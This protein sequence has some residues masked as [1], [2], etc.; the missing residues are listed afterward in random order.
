MPVGFDFGQS[1]QRPTNRLIFGSTFTSGSLRTLCW[2]VALIH[3]A[4]QTR[5]ELTP[6]RP[7]YPRPQLQ[8]ERWLNLNGVW[9][10]EFDD[11]DVGRRR[12]WQRTTAAELESTGGPLAGTIVVPFCPESALSGVGDASFHRVA[13]YG[14]T[15]RTPEHSADER[16]LLNFGAID[17]WAEVWIN[18]EFAGCHEGGHAPFSVD[19]SGY[20]TQTVDTVVVRAEDPGDDPTIPRGKQDWKEQPS[21]IFYNRST[22][23]WQTVW[24]EIVD[25]LHVELL[26]L[27]PD[28]DAG[29]IEVDIR[30]KGWQPG[31]HVRVSC[32]L[33]GEQA[34]AASQLAAGPDLRTAIVL[35]K[36]RIESW[37]PSSPTL[38]DLTIEVV[39]DGGHVRDLV[40]SY[41][42]MRKIEVVGDELRLNGKSVFLRLVLDQGYW[43]DG[44]FTAPSDDALRQDI[45]LA[46]GM[47]F[48]GARKHQKPEDPRWLYWAD[49]LGFLVWGEMANAYSFSHDSVMRTIREW[50]GI[51][52][53]DYNHPCLIAWVPINESSGCRPLADDQRSWAGTFAA[54]YPTTIYHLTKTL[55]PTRP[56]LSNCGAEHT[57]SDF[58]TIHDYRDAAALARRVSSLEDLLASPPGVPPVFADGYAY[59]GQ[60]IFVS[61]YGGIF[62]ARLDDFSYAFASDPEDLA[63]KLEELTSVLLAS[64]IVAGFAYTQLADTAH[65]QNGLLTADR[66]PKIPLERVNA[67]VTSRSIRESD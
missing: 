42:G 23:I 41:F 24:M 2:G 34:G 37:S 21:S 31:T 63:K 53:R 15:V 7:E 22:G 8:R 65:E 28:L 49:R 5:P 35:D 60:P 52:E 61:E 66:K 58:C 57:F 25:S 47:G 36:S 40:G 20:L 59:T 48:N 14:R 51:V 11:K 26:R 44:L 29:A 16:V 43:P 6:P 13:W 64:P 32:S 46:M 56:A 19:V 45:E 18:G 39:D 67:I 54:H 55:D 4:V 38:Y 33:D 12:E 3:Q 17:Y 1:V 30:L 10:Y 62:T 50:A 9:R 27:T